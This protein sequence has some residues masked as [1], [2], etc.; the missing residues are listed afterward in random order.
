M[1]VQL[2]SFDNKAFTPLASVTAPAR[3]T[4]F[5]AGGATCGNTLAVLSNDPKN[6][7]NAQIDFYAISSDNKF[8][9]QGSAAGS[10]L[11]SIA[12]THSEVSTLITF[13]PDCNLLYVAGVDPKTKIEE[14][15]V[16]GQNQSQ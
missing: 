8:T 6:P 16:F 13:S 4:T 7:A 10:A 2:L 9:P 15:D 12:K 14:I 11:P 1:G 5:G 3:E